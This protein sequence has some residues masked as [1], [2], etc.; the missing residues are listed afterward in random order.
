MP[1]PTSVTIPTSA[2]R[3]GTSKSLIRCLIRLLISSDLIPTCLPSLL[4]QQALPHAQQ[5]RSDAA[6]HQMIPHLDGR[7]AE[8]PAV[9]IVGDP[10]VASYPARQRLLVSTPIVPV[11][12]DGCGQAGVQDAGRFIGQ[13]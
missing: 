11:Q 3:M 6:V 5:L 7:A 10:D 1:S 4:F 13:A 2:L 8:E 9:R 12:G